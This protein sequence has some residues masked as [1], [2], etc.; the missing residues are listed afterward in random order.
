[1]I[2]RM[3]QKSKNQDCYQIFRIAHFDTSKTS[4][5]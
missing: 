2:I 4:E 3:N 5:R 1:M